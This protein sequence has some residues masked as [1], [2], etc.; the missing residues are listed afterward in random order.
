MKRRSVVT[1][2][3]KE[4]KSGTHAHSAGRVSDLNQVSV[5]ICGNTLEKS[6]LTVTSVGKL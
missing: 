5:I 3:L 2:K 6:S 1:L 4:E